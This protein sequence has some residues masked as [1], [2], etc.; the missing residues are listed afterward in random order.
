MSTLSESKIITNGGIV[1]TTVLDEITPER[2]MMYMVKGAYAAKYANT[3]DNT[4]VI[5]RE[6]RDL[7]VSPL[8]EVTT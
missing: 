5:P 2:L 3:T 8:E 4:P 1:T 6:I 7:L